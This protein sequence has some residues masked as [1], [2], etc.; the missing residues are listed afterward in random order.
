MSCSFG[1]GVRF[2]VFWPG[3][4]VAIVLPFC[5]TGRVNESSTSFLVP[6]LA[7]S[8]PGGYLAG[9]EYTLVAFSIASGFAQFMALGK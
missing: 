3:W 4:S 5:A 9:S 8:L 6:L 1:A 7:K 2:A